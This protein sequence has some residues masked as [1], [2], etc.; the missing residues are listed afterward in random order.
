MDRSFLEFWGNFLLQVARG[1]KQLE[2]M[3]QWVSQ[4][5]RGFEDMT[6][7]FR[8]AYGLDEVSQESPDQAKVWEKAREDF[9]KSYREYM[10]LFGM[11][12]SQDHLELVRKYEE[13][14]R[15]CEAQEETIKHLRMLLETQG[16]DYGQ[17][18]RNFQDLM[19]SQ[20]EHFQKMMETFGSAFKQPKPPDSDE[21]E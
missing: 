3:N 5:L 2:E 8:K 14:K 21:H 4:G 10:R 15:K 17:M 7:L 19:Q 12:P 11:V 16:G 6:T 18:A 13:L 9:Q 20:S 1:Q